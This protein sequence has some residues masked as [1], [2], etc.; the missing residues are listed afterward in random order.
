MGGYMT[1]DELNSKHP[2]IVSDFIVVA[3]TKSDI[4]VGGGNDYR[5]SNENL[6]KD[7]V[8]DELYA[9]STG[10][11]LYINCLI[12]KVQ[13]WYAKV[14]AEGRYIVFEG[15]VPHDK[16]DFTIPVGVAFGVVGSAI[17]GAN[18]ATKRY[19]YVLDCN[20]GKLSQLNSAYMNE[21]LEFF[22]DLQTQY[23]YVNFPDDKEILLRYITLVNLEY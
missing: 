19:L 12:Q 8:R 1:L 11:T 4:S 21:L 14:L 17:Y 2:S 9:V 6:K 16:N 13:A 15:G 3:R 10:D 18:L 5:V 22:P 20:D 23:S 7:V